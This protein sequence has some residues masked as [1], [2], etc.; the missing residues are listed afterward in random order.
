MSKCILKVR[1]RGL[2]N[3]IRNAG[4]HLREL[5]YQVLLDISQLLILIHRS[6]EETITHPEFIL[7]PLTI[8]AQNKV[9]RPSHFMQVDILA[10]HLIDVV[11]TANGCIDELPT[12]LFCRTRK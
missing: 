12:P 4:I 9:G 11:R 1:R 8:L 2:G 5:A 6:R 7:P 10:S 3:D